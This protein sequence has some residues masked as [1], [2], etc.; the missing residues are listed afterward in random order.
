MSCFLIR[1]LA[2]FFNSFSLLSFLVRAARVLGGLLSCTFFSLPFLVNFFLVHAPSSRRIAHAPS[3][4][5]SPRRTTRRAPPPQPAL[6][7][8]PFLV[9]FLLTR[10]P[11]RNVSF[12]FRVLGFCLFACPSRGGPHAPSPAQEASALAAAEDHAAARGAPPR[13]LSF[14]IPSFEFLVSCLRALAGARRS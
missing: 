14:F 12:F 7:S 4:A 11:P 2:S 13:N 3:P 6:L 10:L 9:N 1:S 8:L 5:Q